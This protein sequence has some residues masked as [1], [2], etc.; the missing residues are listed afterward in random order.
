MKKR[1]AI[2]I[3]II[4]TLGLLCG[5]WITYL[6]K[7]A[8]DKITDAKLPGL[9]VPE[10]NRSLA[11]KMALTAPAI[12]ALALLSWGTVRIFEGKVK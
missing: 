1:R 5:I 4:A 9:N 7:D 12:L 6:W 2:T 10:S 11:N 3:V 8:G